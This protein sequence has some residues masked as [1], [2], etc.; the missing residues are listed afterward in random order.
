MWCNNVDVE[1]EK[2]EGGEGRK[3]KKEWKKEGARELR[4]RKIA[5]REW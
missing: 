3:T 4:K 2:G 1:G 5:K